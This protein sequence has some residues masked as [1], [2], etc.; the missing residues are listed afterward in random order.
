MRANLATRHGLRAWRRLF[1]VT[2]IVT[3]LVFARDSDAQVQV[4][5]Q[6]TRVAR[7]LAKK[8]VK[9]DLLGACGPEKDRK[10]VCVQIVSSIGEVFG[11]VIDGKIDSDHVAALLRS[12][13]SSIVQ[14][15]AA[16][17]GEGVVEKVMKSVTPSTGKCS[18]VGLAQPVA[19]CLVARAYAGKT[20]AARDCQAADQALRDV[21]ANCE[22]P[23][24][25]GATDT[26]DLLKEATQV[27]EAQAKDVPEVYGAVL[28]LAQ[29]GKIA[30]HASSGSFYAIAREV[31]E[32]H[33]RVMEDMEVLGSHAAFGDGDITAVVQSTD[34]CPGRDQ[35]VTRATAWEKDRWSTFLAVSRALS[36]FRALPPEAMSKLP[37]DLPD[38]RCPASTDALEAAARRLRNDA[39]NFRVDATLLAATQDAVLPAM[40]VAILIDYVR[41]GDDALLGQS[42]RDFVLQ[43]LARVIAA[44][45]ATDEIACDTIANNGGLSC[46]GTS[47]GPARVIAHEPGVAD[48]DLYLLVASRHSPR[49]AR[50]TC[51]YQAAASLLEGAFPTFSGIGTRCRTSAAKLDRTIFGD[52]L[53]VLDKGAGVAQWDSKEVAKSAIPGF[54]SLHF[55]SNVSA[56]DASQLLQYMLS[57]LAAASGLP[58]VDRLPVETAVHAMAIGSGGRRDLLRVAADLFRPKLEVALD[59]FLPGTG[60]CTASSSP[61]SLTCGVRVLLDAAYD[62][63]MT[64]VSEPNPTNE[65]RQRLAES[66]LEQLDA[67]DSLGRSP[68]LFDIGPGATMLTGLGA[69]G[70]TYH[71]T[72]VDKYGWAPVRFGPRNEWQ[73]G[74]FVGGFIDALVQKLAGTSDVASY[75]LSGAAFGIRQFSKDFPF[76]IEV[77]AASAIH[78]HLTHFKDNLGFATGLNLLVPIDEAFGSSSK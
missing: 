20:G 10:P 30:D 67:L 52:S 3:A 22:G 56:S 58:D 47:S 75:W 68:L 45:E 21:L 66:F 2:L 38:P 71:L 78:F 27:L 60:N 19:A 77:Y 11:M 37:V 7:D 5:D 31:A 53:T 16:D 54:A 23:K 46:Q 49:S 9:S 29:L 24:P 59:G 69:T 15:V 64:Y 17:L 55:A 28:V 32:S 26:L 50:Q 42:L 76:G 65:D 39:R 33:A 12:E 74:V 41:T 6:F 1:T 40:L 72:L 63:V 62:P 4:S 48:D 73:A 61:T 8:V 18:A 43:G 35:V 57:P 13:F 51:V 25:Q 44:A 34:A 14:A 36:Q 70:I